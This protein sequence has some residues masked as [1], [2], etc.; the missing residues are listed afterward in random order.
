MDVSSTVATWL[1]FAA[2]VVGLG[3]I[4]TQF[5][6]I[7]DQADPF[8]ALRDPRHLGSWWRRQTPGTWYSLVKPP[9][10]GP[11]ISANLSNGLCGQKTV[12]LS[13]LPIVYPPGQAAWSILL[14]VIH[15]IPRVNDYQAMSSKNPSADHIVGM[16][17]IVKITDVTFDA[18]PSDS[19]TEIPLRPLTRH[20]LTTCT[21]ITRGTLMALLCLTNA[22]PVFRHSSACGHRAAYA[23]YCGQWRVEW[24]IGDLARVYFCA[25]DSHTMS[26]DT[27]PTV[28]EQRVDKCLQML[29]GVIDSRT[30]TTL[31]V[32]FPGRKQSGKWI[33][34][35]AV[36]GF[37]G[38]HGGR[39]LY[40]MIGGNVNEVDYLVMKA[41][42]SEREFS[43]DIILY[44]PSTTGNVHEVT[45]Y[46]PE[47]EAAVLNE[48]LDKLPW[49]FMSWSIHRGLRD[50]LMAFSKE[51]MDLYRSCLAD[52]LRSTVAKWPERLDAR[53]WN[54][55]FVRDDMADIAASA[56]LAGQ[57][58]SG[59]AVRVVTE[60]AAVLWDG[61]KFGLDETQFWRCATPEPCSST[62]SPPTV[63][64]LVKCFVLEWSVDLDYQ[65]YHDLPL[66]MY[67]G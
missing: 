5:G 52:T 38:A 31:K 58:N 43:K 20:K 4:A 6:T 64:A 16:E 46:V 15:P 27:Y 35:Y 51:K 57:G 67:L 2:T 55:R 3:S 40:N 33:L 18:I 59:D 9:P 54:P 53:G 36:K 17:H 42:E 25:H 56:V 8:H 26:T 37:G 23:A 32:A 1:S 61:T 7:I 30:S 50:I 10:I 22:R 24:P 41:T 48:V 49:A 47:R 34:K 21:L 63:V 44:L 11:V 12:Y 29:A 66:E 60:I 62:L 39:H 45:L 13:R 19:W 65:M 14:A 28:F